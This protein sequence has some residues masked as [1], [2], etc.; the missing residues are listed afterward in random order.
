[1][2]AKVRICRNF[3]IGIFVYEYD[4]IFFSYK[5]PIKTN[6]YLHVHVKIDQTDIRTKALIAKI[7]YCNKIHMAGD[8]KLFV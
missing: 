6:V 7:A 8:N 2:H 3:Q 1:M 5:I 4:Q